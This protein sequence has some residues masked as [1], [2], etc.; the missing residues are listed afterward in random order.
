MITLKIINK[1]KNVEQYNQHYNPFLVNEACQ[2]NN[3]GI[4]FRDIDEQGNQIDFKF[5]PCDV[6]MAL[7]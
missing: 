3:S 4:T 2:L 1:K 5:R 7:F 6:E